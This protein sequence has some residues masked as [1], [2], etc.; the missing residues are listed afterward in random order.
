MK[1]GDRNACKMQEIPM[2]E[3]ERMSLS[4]RQA[5]HKAQHP[6]DKNVVIMKDNGEPMVGITWS[7]TGKQ[8]KKLQDFYKAH[9]YVNGEW[10]CIVGEEE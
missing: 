10:V 5:Q 9:E 2:R 7:K 8:F 6:N 1:Y 4:E 3:Y